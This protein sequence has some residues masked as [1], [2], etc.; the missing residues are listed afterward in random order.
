MTENNENNEADFVMLGDDELCT[1]IDE[2][3]ERFW[4]DCDDDIFNEIFGDYPIPKTQ[5]EY[6][7]Y[8]KNVFQEKYDKLPFYK[9]IKCPEKF[10]P[11]INIYEII[12]N[13]LANINYEYYCELE[14]LFETNEDQIILNAEKQINNILRKFQ[15]YQAGDQ[16]PVEEISQCFIN[17]ISFNNFLIS[18]ENENNMSRHK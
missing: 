7:T 16:I 3:I 8:I 17:T 14:Q 2:A 12:D 15:C 13:E 9:A 11:K 1:D 18:N 4:N 10:L 5:E 6:K